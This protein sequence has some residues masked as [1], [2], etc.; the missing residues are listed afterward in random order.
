[1]SSILSE[2]GP[3]AA[4]VR[5]E[6]CV[7]GCRPVFLWG[8]PGVGKSDIVRQVAYAQGRKVIDVRAVMLD[9]VDIKGL[10]HVEAV[11]K[12]DWDTGL[13]VFDSNGNPVMEKIS[14]WAV[15]NF[16]PRKNEPGIFF[17][18]ELP[19][20][21]PLVQ[22]ACL[23][24]AL[25][26]RVGDYELPPQ[27]QIVAAG[28]RQGD[29][30]GAHALITPLLNRFI[31][32]DV[33]PLLDDWLAWATIPANNVHD[34]VVSYLRFSPVQDAKIGRKSDESPYGAIS[35]FDSKLRA[36]PSPRSWK[37]VSDIE[38]TNP[39]DDVMQS[40]VF[41]TVGESRGSEYMSMR[42]IIS[43]LPDVDALIANPMMFKIT[44]TQ[45]ASDP[46]MLYALVGAVSGRCKTKDLTKLEKISQ[47]IDM[48]PQ[49]FKVKILR[50]AT[51]LS[52][53]V[54]CRTTTFS[55]MFK[56]PQIRS[57]FANPDFKLT[58]ADPADMSLLQSMLAS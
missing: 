51:K 43:Q 18:D 4:A 36:F 34:N 9:P 52:E 22:S 20:A 21:P 32:I 17:L 6:Y 7:K 15:P 38:H 46:A 16:F 44:M 35:E 41:G 40:L 28:N 53:A 2:V 56:Q 48:L 26:R 27:W 3:A 57:L 33:A 8:S 47:V 58:D 23:Q 5:V 39:P 14:S 1:M 30:A 19:Q 42:K 37:H 24:L 11:S 29:K 13:P 12:E 49:E 31:H 50:D 54:I 45:M 25:D 55:T 10:P